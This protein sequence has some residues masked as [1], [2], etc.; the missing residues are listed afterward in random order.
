[1]EVESLKKI[2]VVGNENSITG[3]GEFRSDVLDRT[4]WS[5]S[6]SVA[7]ITGLLQDFNVHPV[8]DRQ[9]VS[10]QGNYLCK[11]AVN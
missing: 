5:K 4:H 1:M 2:N 6:P 7:Y 3:S 11:N 9:K 8:T 10:L